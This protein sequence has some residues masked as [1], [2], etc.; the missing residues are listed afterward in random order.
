M[1]TQSTIIQ[2]LNHTHIG[3]FLQLQYEV[4]SHLPETEKHYIKVR[5]AE[6]LK[7]H[8][9]ENMPLLGVFHNGILSGA[10]MMTYPD[11]LSAQHMAGY[12]FDYGV[13]NKSDSVVIQSLY[14]SPNAQGLGLSSA[15]IGA[16]A[17]RALPGRPY[18]VAKTVASN[19]K[20]QTAFLKNGFNHF[21][22]GVDPTY[23]HD[24]C[25][26]TAKAHD[27]LDTQ[28]QKRLARVNATLPVQPSR[29]TI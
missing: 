9:A 25:Y 21:A 10:V 4:R 17:E 12:P 3:A 24:V 22:V 2:A 14:V 1:T 23:G 6:V 8:M 28:Q 11:N 26:L 7:N 18:L 19:K 20:S 29:L 5:S 13:L 16:V 27:V 15:L